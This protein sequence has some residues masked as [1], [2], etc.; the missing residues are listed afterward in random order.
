MVFPRGICISSRKL[1]CIEYKSSW[2]SSTNNK[3]DF[4]FQIPESAWLPHEYVQATI[5]RQ[6]SYFIAH[7]FGLG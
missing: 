4:L 3:H 6:K 7:D 1:P 2:C 5:A